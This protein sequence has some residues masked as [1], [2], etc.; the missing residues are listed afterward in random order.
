MQISPILIILAAGVLGAG[1]MAVT[2]QRQHPQRRPN[3]LLG[4]V[5]GAGA[6]ALGSMLFTV[7]LNYC[8]FEAERVSDNVYNLYFGLL[9]AAAGALLLLYPVSFA[10]GRWQQNGTWRAVFAAGAQQP[11]QGVFKGTVAPILLLAPTLTILLLFLYYPSLDTIRLST[12]LARLGAPRTAFVCVDNFT[13]LVEPGSASRD[14][15]NSLGNTVFMSL[16]IVVL[17]L[18]LSL[19][20]AAMA[21]LPIKG[22]AVYRTLLIWPYAISPAIAGI[23]FLLMFNPTGGIINFFSDRFFGI[24]LGWTNDANVAPWTIIIASIWKSLGYNVLFYLAGLQ[25]VSKDMIE[26]GSIDGANA[27]QRFFY[28][29]MPQLSPITFFL[30]VTNTTYAFFDTFA[31]IDYLTPGGGPLQST[32]TQMYEIYQLGIG[33]NDLGKAAAQSIVLFAMVIALTVLQFRFS[34]RRVNYG[35]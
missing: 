29:V 30:I 24:T 32:T 34:G 18:A 23:I 26:A 12:L 21:Y 8:M 17:G 15:F 5:L 27:F 20:I 11:T 31:T 2:F 6:G 35:A 33:N 1:W 13:R 22:A 7:P 16:A 19:F 9:L 28:L 14:F 25:N 3:L 10:A 4:L